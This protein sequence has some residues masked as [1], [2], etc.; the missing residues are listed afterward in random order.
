M[1]VYNERFYV[2]EAVNSVLAVQF[3]EGVNIE[4]VVIDDGSTDGTEKI[5]DRFAQN[6]NRLHLLRHDQ[7]RG[8]G[9]AIRTAIRKATGD[10]IV[11]QD[12]DLEYDPT[13]LPKL[14]EPILEGE[15]DVVY[16][17][18]FRIRER[19]R[20]LLFWHSIGNRIITLLSNI[21]TNLYLTDIETCYKMARA[22]ILK[23]I[24]IRANRFSIEPELTAKFAKRRCRIYEVPISYRGRT[25]R[26]GK[27]I[28]WKDGFVALFTI[29]KYWLIDD[30]YCK[31]YGHD[32][33]FSLSRTYHINNWTADVIRPYV[34]NRV[35]EIGAGL[36]NITLELLPCE[37]YTAT[38]IDNLHL[39]YLHNFF[40]NNRQV[41]V[42]RL[43]VETPADFER[44]K[45]SLDT[46]VC[47]NVLEHIK[48]DKQA[49]HNIYNALET[50]G[51]LCLLV[52]RGHWLYGT[53]DEALEHHRRYSRDEIY[54][55]VRTTG[56]EIEKSFT[57]NKV[58]VPAW[59]LNAHI[60]KRKRFS[61]LQLK[62]FDSL[63]WLWR[64]IDRFLPWKGISYIIIARKTSKLLQ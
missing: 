30:A 51:R 5:L 39:D 61:R 20:V 1:P 36:G 47:L 45:V 15:A 54:D 33:L 46:V 11:V 10:V 38:D 18:R 62:I 60:L 23:S 63:T 43:N 14:L 41:T 44:I 50:N 16:G 22:S 40:A 57:F 53:L 17:S 42:Q 9:A 55:L 35:L 29:L 52:P 34:G 49:L 21:F 59:F 37:S 28:T 56:F 64:R 19:A 31:K 6:E 48:N 58:G 13:E 8:K 2:E 24:P 12:A 3:P 26:E 4:L 25:Y 7:N 32:I 27:K